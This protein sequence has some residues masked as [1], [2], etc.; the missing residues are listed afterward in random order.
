[1]VK[2][3]GKRIS[4]TGIENIL[5]YCPGVNDAAVISV[6]V[7]GIIR[8]KALWAVVAAS[9]EHALSTQ[10]IQAF[11]QKRLD[12]VEIPRRILIVDRLPRNSNGKLP[13][14]VLEEMFRLDEKQDV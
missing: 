5:T 3:A 2:I 13:R 1:M 7:N 9:A 8:D 10:I 4:L 6:P 11:L 14:K 12:S